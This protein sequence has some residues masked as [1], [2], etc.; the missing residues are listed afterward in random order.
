[1][2]RALTATNASPGGTIKPFWLAP[3][4][5]SARNASM[6]NGAAASEATTSTTKSAGC[7]ARS[8]AARSAARSLVMPLAV[9]VC[10]TKTAV[11][12]CAS[13]A[14]STASISA[15]SIGKP[16][17]QGVRI[18]RPPI[19]SVCTAHDSEKCPVP[20]TSTAW[21]GATRLAMTASH[22][23]WPLAA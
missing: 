1:M 20:G 6:A 22:A 10:T 3:S 8:M 14:R 7:P 2:A 18:T 19:A 21:P 11:I 13:S 15:G 5:T 4:A 12:S 16:S 17:T 9:S 23:P